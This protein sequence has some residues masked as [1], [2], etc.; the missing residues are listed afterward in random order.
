MNQN[1]FINLIGDPVLPDRLPEEPA[2]DELF[3]I[4]DL[5]MFTPQPEITD[6]TRKLELLTVDTNTH[7]LRIEIE[8]SKRQRLQATMKQLRQDLSIAKTDITML[9][10]EITQLREQQNII[11]FQLDNENAR[12]NTLSFRSL[13]R[14]GQI[15]LTLV[16]NRTQL[17][18]IGPET[19]ILLQELNTTI[20]QFGVYYH[21]SHI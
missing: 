18:E 10:S 8:R 14:I 2:Y 13:S 4:D 7:G 20:R 5:M 16:P 21:A 6:L 9:R 19:E 1:N 17:S 12:T 3:P 15:L 11:N